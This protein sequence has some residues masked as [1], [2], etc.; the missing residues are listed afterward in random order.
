MGN[1]TDIPFGFVKM[2]GVPDNFYINEFGMVYNSELNRFVKAHKLGDGYYHVWIK[3]RFYRIHR[4]VAKH[5]VKNNTGGNY[6]QFFD[7]KK[8]HYQASNLFWG[9]CKRGN[10]KRPMLRVPVICINNLMCFSSVSSAAKITGLDRR[11]IA[12][13]CTGKLKTTGGLT[14]RYRIGTCKVLDTD[15]KEKLVKNVVY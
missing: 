3:G 14:F 15:K 1:I 13:T 6:V 7:N 5:F 10:H 4:F 12:K 8:E 9:K 2:D 11:N